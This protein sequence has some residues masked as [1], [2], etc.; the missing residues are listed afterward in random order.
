[1]KEE[2]IIDDL[3]ST[4]YYYDDFSLDAVL[5]KY[6]KNSQINIERLKQRLIKEN[7]I[8]QLPQSKSEA[9]AMISMRGKN[10]VNAGGYLFFYG[11][12]SQRKREKEP[13]FIREY[14]V[15]AF[16]FYSYWPLFFIGLI[17][18]IAI[19]LII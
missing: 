16:Q 18:L 14:K 15:P 19:L 8:E 2:E 9:N 7:L 12:K 5:K 4:Y 10:L 11:D 17:Q 13:S 1:M 6:F 3:L